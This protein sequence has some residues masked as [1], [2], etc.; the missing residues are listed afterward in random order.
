ME[1]GFASVWID[2]RR[3][4]AANQPVTLEGENTQFYRYEAKK[5]GLCRN[6]GSPFNALGKLGL[7]SP[8]FPLISTDTDF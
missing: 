5:R 8:C 6:L 4:L 2:A 1:D 7:L 3:G